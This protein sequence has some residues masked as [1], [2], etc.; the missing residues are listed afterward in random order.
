MD[1]SGGAVSDM[2]QFSYNLSLSAQPQK[3]VIIQINMTRSQNIPCIQQN[4]RLELVTT[5]LTFSMANYNTSQAVIAV[6]KKRDKYEGPMSVTFEHRVKTEDEVWQAPFLLP[7][8]LTLLDGDPCENGAAPLDT[9]VKTAVGDNTTVRIC[10]CGEGYFVNQSDSTF[11]GSATCTECTEGMIC[12]AKDGEE[13]YRNLNLTLIPIEPGFYRENSNSSVVVKCPVKRACAGKNKFAG[14]DLCVEGHSGPMCQVCIV[15]DELTY[16]WSDGQCVPCESS[17]DGTIYGLLIVVLL[18]ASVVAY[19]IVIVRQK[20]YEKWEHL[21]EHFSGRVLTKYKIVVK[22]L[23]TLCKVTTLYPDITFPAVFSRVTDKLNTFVD[24]DIN[25][26]P[27]NCVVSS[28][29]FHDSLLLMTLAPLALISFIALVYFY[30]RDQIL[31]DSCCSCP[32]PCSLSVD[33]SQ[34][35]TLENLPQRFEEANP[36]INNF[37]EKA[38]EEATLTISVKLGDLKADCIY[39]ALV[40]LY[41]IFSLVSTTIIQTFNYDHRLKAVTGDSY[42]IADYTIRQSDADHKAY[43]IYAVIMFLVYSVGIPAVSLYFL[44]MHK[45]DIQKLQESVYELSQLQEAASRE[46]ERERGVKNNKLQSSEDTKPEDE[47]RNEE[48]DNTIMKLEEGQPKWEEE[49]RETTQNNKLQSSEDTKPEDEEQK[50][51]KKLEVKE[52]ILLKEQAKLL[53]ENPMLRG[54][55]PLYQDYEAEHYYFEV[56]QF[57]V[58][59]FLVA[60]A[61]CVPLLPN[62]PP[63]RSSPPFHITNKFNTC[64]CIIP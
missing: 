39:Y 14:D 59:L 57:V 29:N 32:H 9:Q 34:P 28:A 47:E 17:H 26:L 1:S 48:Q 50:A 25:I 20:N 16:V 55:A 18:L 27:F 64:I 45:T 38:K 49:Q 22:L 13:A 33:T 24:L 15:T 35:I 8:S 41:T 51:V 10:Q 56:I 6:A 11:C 19:R 31:R 4:E 62:H 2:F 43:V 37:A 63:P 61:V 7:V 12:R 60:V 54:L 5:N 58:T 46:R 42:L 21:R 3:D 23:Q 30:R 36:Y 53:Q 44:W 52:P 40:F